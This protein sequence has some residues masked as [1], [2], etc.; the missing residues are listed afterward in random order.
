MVMVVC[1]ALNPERAVQRA[2]GGSG[3]EMWQFRVEG[4]TRCVPRVAVIVL[5]R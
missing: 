1:S 5:S 4:H 2:R 3:W